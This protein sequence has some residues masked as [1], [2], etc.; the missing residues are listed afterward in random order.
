MSPKPNDLLVMVLGAL[1]ILLAACQQKEAPMTVNKSNTSTYFSVIDFT[2]DQWSTFRGQPY[3]I[4]QYSTVNGRTDSAILSALT[5]K[6][7]SIFKAFFAS[8]I[9]DPKFLNQYDF[10]MF[11]EPTTAARTFTY[12]AKNP[13][14]FTQKLQI[15]AD[16]YNNKIRSIYIET[17]K[18]DFWSTTTQ[19][20]YYSPVRVI[21]IQ[22]HKDPL[23]GSQKDRVLEYKFM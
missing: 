4:H 19:K 17:Q 11:E 7:S 9:G 12:T 3:V 14:L 18:Q 22:E 21:Q 23:I 15:L 1:L 8:D 6:W 16:Y 5:M 13:E 2:K 20:L 10:S